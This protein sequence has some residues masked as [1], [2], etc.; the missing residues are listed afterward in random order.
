[1]KK[2]VHLKQFSEDQII[3]S[4]DEAKMVLKFFWP[5]KSEEIDNATLSERTIG[6]AQG[7]LVEAIDTSYAYGYVEALFDVIVSVILPSKSNDRAAMRIIKKFAK[8]AST[9]WFKHATANDLMHVKI[10]DA[11][12]N[13]IANAF[14]PQLYNYLHDLA[15]NGH[16]IAFI[17]YEL[18]G[19]EKV[20]S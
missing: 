2:T 8:K 7:L 3:L 4:E 14:G 16:C 19:H 5:G 17:G 6:F 18:C 9:H 10:Y 15:S 12:R 1:M 20:W 11:V 13:H